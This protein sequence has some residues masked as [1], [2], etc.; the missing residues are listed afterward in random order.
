MT[1]SIDAIGD[2]SNINERQSS[3]NDEIT[4]RSAKSNMNHPSRVLGLRRRGFGI[5]GGY[6]R[7]Y[8][9]E[10]KEPESD[11]YGP[12]PH[13]GYYGAGTGSRPF[14]E[15]EAT[16]NQELSWYRK[17]YGTQTSGYNEKKN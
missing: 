5:G 14:K 15:G 6:E 7:R 8:Q 11:V 13:A 4:F 2:S 12:L 9:T 3:S 16:F 10:Q 17:Q 1:K